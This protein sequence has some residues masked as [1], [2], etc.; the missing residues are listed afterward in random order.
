MEVEEGPPNSCAKC[1]DG[2]V[3]AGDGGGGD[4]AVGKVRRLPTPGAMSR[5]YWKRYEPEVKTKDLQKQNCEIYLCVFVGMCVC[6]A[7]ALKP[8][9]VRRWAESVQFFNA[10]WFQ[11]I[12]FMPAYLK[13]DT[14]M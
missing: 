10:F 11:I 9:E 7:F 5:S 8:I 4:L 2:D 12:F 1:D 14:H 3:D 6:R 13:T